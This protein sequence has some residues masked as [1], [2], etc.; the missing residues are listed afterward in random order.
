MQ[1]FPL[2]ELI[3]FVVPLLLFPALNVSALR[4]FSASHRFRI[5]KQNTP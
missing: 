2:A 1:H 5:P 3:P 4:K